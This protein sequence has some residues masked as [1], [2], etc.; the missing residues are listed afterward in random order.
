M[1]WLRPALSLTCSCD[2]EETR[3]L[4][5]VAISAN[6][7]SAR[8]QRFFLAVSLRFKGCFEAQA[9]N[10]DPAG[11]V[12]S[13]T[14]CRNSYSAAAARSPAPHGATCAAARSE[15]RLTGETR[16]LCQVGTAARRDWSPGWRLL[17]ALRRSKAAARLLIA[18]LSL[19][20]NRW[21]AQFGKMI[22][23]S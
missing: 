14:Y 1:S 9:A 23:P 10:P 21:C 13:V 17:Q 15:S 16:R 22:G 8:I 2:D 6:H 7:R 11:L 12:C 18:C 4:Q 5:S 3:C 19:R 20:C